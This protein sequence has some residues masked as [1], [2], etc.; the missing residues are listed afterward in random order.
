M[1]SQIKSGMWVRN[2]FLLGLDL[3]FCIIRFLILYVGTTW[4]LPRQND[5]YWSDVS[6]RTISRANLDGSGVT[7]LVN[8]EISVVGK[9][10][11]YT[12]SGSPHNDL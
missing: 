3:Y 4:I 2:Y 8:S 12:R 6:T 9:F 5:M 11:R 10:C 1:N 7:T